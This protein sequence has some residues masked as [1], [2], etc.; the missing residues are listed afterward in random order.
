MT[1]AQKPLR[2]RES[3]ERG[4]MA[5]LA[6]VDEQRRELDTIERGAPDLER[7]I[8]AT[9]VAVETKCYPARW[10][11]ADQLPTQDFPTLRVMLQ[12]VNGRRPGPCLPVS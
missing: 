11:D 5:E 6:L 2:E 8:R 10:F 3:R 4:R 12:P 9:V 7:Q 1:N